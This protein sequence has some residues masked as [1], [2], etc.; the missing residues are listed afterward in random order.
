M[1]DLALER[2]CISIVEEDQEAS[3]PHMFIYSVLLF[4][5]YWVACWSPVWRGHYAEGHQPSTVPRK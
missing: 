5:L 2:V 3:V 4:V 1:Q